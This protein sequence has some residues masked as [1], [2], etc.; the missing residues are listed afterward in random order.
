MPISKRPNVAR[1][2]EVARDFDGDITIRYRGEDGQAIKLTR[3]KIKS[4]L[5]LPNR[6]LGCSPFF[7]PP[8][9]GVHQEEVKYVTCM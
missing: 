9:M 1:V 5:V 8:E 4:I 6:V 2:P 3:E 7:G